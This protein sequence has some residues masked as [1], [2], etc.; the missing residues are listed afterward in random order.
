MPQC[1]YPFAL[2]AIAGAA[3]FAILAIFLLN[4]NGVRN[5]PALAK[6][7]PQQ[8][9]AVHLAVVVRPLGVAKLTA[10]DDGPCSKPKQQAQLA[11]ELDPK[12]P[13]V[14]ATPARQ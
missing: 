1:A 10:R 13:W 12:F 3:D 11:L 5:S 6:G 4:Y 8:V 2:Y 7:T 9:A 14:L